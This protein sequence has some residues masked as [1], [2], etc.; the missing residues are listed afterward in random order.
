MTTDVAARALRVT[1]RTIRVYIEQGKLDAKPQ[2]EG[3]RKKWLVSIDSLHALRDTR[4]PSAQYIRE[5]SAEEDV[6]ADLF[7]EI[8]DRLE[9]RAAEAAELRTRLVITG[10]AE[11]TLREERQRLLEDLERERER[12]QEALE[13]V[14]EGRRIANQ[15]QQQRNAARQEA[16]RLEQE[17]EAERQRVEQDRQRT[18]EEAN[19][20][21]EELKAERSKGFFRRLFGR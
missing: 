12:A 8:A 17:F 19:R 3:V 16:D 21:R 20:L 1:P 9:F 11:S 4:K 2:G 10:R 5:V 6:P 15:L 7:R 18:Q 13:R 14:E